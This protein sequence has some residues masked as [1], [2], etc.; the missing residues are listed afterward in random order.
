MTAA[1]DYSGYFRQMLGGVSVTAQL[2]LLSFAISLVAGTFLGILRLVEK[3]AVQIPLAV[4]AS[5]MT[6]VPS[7]L[8]LFIIYYGGSGVLTAMF[9]YNRS[10]DISPFASG[11]AAISLVNAAYVADL[12]HGAIRNVP[13]GQF[14]ACTMLC[15][16]RFQAWRLVLLPQVFRLA[17]P[18]LVNIWIVI[19]KETSLVSLVGLHDLVTVAKT[20]GGATREPFLF[21]IVASVFYVVVS[22]LTVPA[23]NALERWLNRGHTRVGV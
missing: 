19:L 8:I 12:V 15:L 3:R 2:M 7:L 1:V 23:S 17:L 16:P 11:V 14:E 5:I 4:Y 18:G 6:G 13:K 22:T 20:A 9:G 10:F 21:L